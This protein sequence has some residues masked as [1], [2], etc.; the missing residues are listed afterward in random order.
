MPHRDGLIDLAQTS[1]AELAAN[2]AAIAAGRASGINHITTI[3]WFLPEVPHA[4]VGGVRTVF[5]TAEHLS[6]KQ[7][8]LH[9][10][11]IFCFQEQPFDPAPLAESLRVHFPDLSFRIHILRHGIDRAN[12][13]PGADIAICTLWTTAYVMLRY[14]QCRRKFY[15]MQDYEPLFYA[16]GDLAMLIEQTYRMGYSCI[17]NTPGVGA[18]YLRY[19]AD[20][21][22]FLPGVDRAQFHPPSR[23][24]KA[25]PHRLVFYGR[26]ERARNG[27][28]LGADILRKLKARLGHKIR[29]TSVGA[30]WQPSDYG[31]AGVVDNLGLLKSIDEVAALYRDADLGL[32]LMATPHP[33][34]QP[35]E[36]MASGTIVATNINEANRWLL[37]DDNALLIEPVPE[38][39]AERIAALLAD[40]ARRRQ[41]VE[42][43]L[44]T[45]QDLNWSDAFDVIEAR[46]MA[47][48]PLASQPADITA[49]DPYSDLAEL[50]RRLLAAEGEL[51]RTQTALQGELT[52]R[53][54]LPQRIKRGVKRRLTAPL[55][56]LLGR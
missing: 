44:A 51:H 20:M 28:F 49:P 25:G 43:G 2:T 8:T 33:S 13:L 12:D 53:S 40:P 3:T 37:S 17:A 16:G 22:S 36:Y 48:H 45:V 50:T 47:D 56:R 14:N 18:H 6:R 46:L 41:L 21:V 23:P 9:H 29:I 15:F 54:E 38:V 32:V 10:F 30:D 31:L 42:N 5:Q 24:R 26:P 39:A 35:L 27:F 4:L 7:G 11:V 19:S 55:K 52:R 1:A 34:Y